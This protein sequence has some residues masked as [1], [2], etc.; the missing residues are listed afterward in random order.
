[1]NNVSLYDPKEQST[2][3]SLLLQESL[4]DE[5]PLEDVQ[6]DEATIEEESTETVALMREL[7]GDGYLEEDNIEDEALMDE[8]A[9]ESMLSQVSIQEGAPPNDED[10][11]QLHGESFVNF[12]A[13][14]NTTTRIRVTEKYPLPEGNSR[15]PPTNFISV[16]PRCY[17]TTPSQSMFNNHQ[18]HCVRRAEAPEKPKWKKIVD[19]TFEGCERS[20][21]DVKS[22]KR[23]VVDKHSD[24]SR[25]CEE[26]GCEDK[27][28]YS[29]RSSFNCHKT[30]DHSEA[31]KDFIPTG[32]LF[33]GCGVT[34]FYDKYISY[35]THL[36]RQHGLIGHQKK[37]YLSAALAT[38]E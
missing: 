23:L 9:E 26:P 32:C 34:T 3:T 20:F 18:V 36:Y 22:M 17:Y 29:S 21:S 27:P 35:S 5:D 31:A 12:F 4:D 10:P 6:D 30:T 7:F 2:E 33:P 14:I 37:E 16:C 8:M 1:M 38:E 13:A 15:D 11:L 25:K 19:C 24:Y 28:P